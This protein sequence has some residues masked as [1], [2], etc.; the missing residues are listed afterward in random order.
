MTEEHD[1]SGIPFEERESLTTKEAEQ[2]DNQLYSEIVEAISAVPEFNTALRR[3]FF[4]PRRHSDDQLTRVDFARGPNRYEIDLIYSSG[5]TVRRSGPVIEGLEPNLNRLSRSDYSYYYKEGGVPEE[6]EEYQFGYVG[7][8]FTY[9]HKKNNYKRYGDGHC[10]F[11]GQQYDVYN[12]TSQPELTI[13]KVR[14]FIEKI[15]GG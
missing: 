5:L 4:Q 7:R 12:L 8:D 6:E 2:I 14:D 1:K 9:S 13:Q 3:K 15:K 11:L 10:R